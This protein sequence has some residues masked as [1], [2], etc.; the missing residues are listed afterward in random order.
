VTICTVIG[1]RVP[2]QLDS[3][4]AE[5]RDFYIRFEL[6]TTPVSSGSDDVIEQARKRAG[7]ETF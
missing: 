2:V 7:N 3:F 5:F 1:Y 4:T 6:C